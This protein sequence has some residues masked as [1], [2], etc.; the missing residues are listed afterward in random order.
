MAEA[1]SVFTL[2]SFSLLHC[3]LLHVKVVLFII[4]LHNNQNIVN[5]AL[6]NIF[7]SACLC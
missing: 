5:R 7:Y 1:S 3:K 6:L 4:F 2:R